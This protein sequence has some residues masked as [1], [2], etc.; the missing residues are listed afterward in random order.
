[1]VQQLEDAGLSFTGKDE[2]G[3]RMEVILS[4]EHSPGTAWCFIPSDIVVWLSTFYCR[5][6]SY[7]AI[8]TSLPFNFTQSSSR[9]QES[10]PPCFQ[11]PFRCIRHISPTKK[12]LH[13]LELD[14]ATGLV[15]AACGQLDNLLKKGSSRTCRLSSNGT[16]PIKPHFYENAIPNGALVDGIYCNGNGLHA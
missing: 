15:A 6:L 11:V 4:S 7:I 1:M 2:S 12:L 13:W 9:D 10:P 3:C 5:S 14:L 8:H 16:S